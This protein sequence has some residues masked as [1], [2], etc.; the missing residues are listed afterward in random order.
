MPV[1]SENPREIHDAYKE[2][3]VDTLLNNLSARL[4]GRGDFYQVIY[5]T[6]PSTAL[7]SEFIVPMPPDERG[8]D[9]E[10]DPIRISAHGMDFQIRSD[11]TTGEQIGIS[12]TGSVYVRILPTEDEVKPGGV[13]EPS[14][15]LTREA[16]LAIRSKVK[17]AL[18]ELA[19]ELVGARTHPEWAAKSYEARKGVYESLGVP[20]D[21][22]LDRDQPEEN[23]EENEEPAESSDEPQP[24][25]SSQFKT[26]VGFD[27]CRSSSC[28]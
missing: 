5:G 26:R 11:A 9:E 1:L 20:F 21:N 12:V 17:E 16:R 19:A 8:G 13:L 25:S 7:M 18:N 22:R 23:A 27:T 4:A 3:V 2:A 14:F 6:K 15:P 28:D 10:A 24:S